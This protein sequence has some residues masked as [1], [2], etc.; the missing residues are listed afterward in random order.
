[1]ENEEGHKNEGMP[2]TSLTFCVLFLWEIQYRDHVRSFCSCE[3]TF[4]SRKSVVS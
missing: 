3:A 1:M 4:F 2:L